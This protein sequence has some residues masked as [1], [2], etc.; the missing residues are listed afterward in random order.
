[1]DVSEQRSVNARQQLSILV[2]E[3]RCTRLR[4]LL[5]K[6]HM[7]SPC[8]RPTVEP[9]VHST[10][11]QLKPLFDV[12]IG[13]VSY[14]IWDPVSSLSH[15]HGRPSTSSLLACYIR[16]SPPHSHVKRQPE[17]K[18]SRCTVFCR[19]KTSPSRAEGTATLNGGLSST[20]GT[21]HF[22]SYSHDR[23]L[24]M[25]RSFLLSAD[26]VKPT[27]DQLQKVRSNLCED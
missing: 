25:G 12:G 22:H 10:L 14:I 21:V 13:G 7:P 9:Y 1:M 26:A 20:K 27:L 18:L 6:Q 2:T 16:S 4:A 15:S 17:L 3:L 24:H 5:W 19:W 11:T 8:R 23:L